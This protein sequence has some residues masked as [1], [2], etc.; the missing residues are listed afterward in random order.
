MSTKPGPLVPPP[1]PGKARHGGWVAAGLAGLVVLA[2][3]ARHLAAANSAAAPGN[4]V[5]SSA[6]APYPSSPVN[7]D[8]V[9]TYNA[10]SSQV[11]QLSGQLGA[12]QGHAQDS[13]IPIGIGT[14]EQL[15]M[16]NP[17][18]LTQTQAAVVH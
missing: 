2:V 14:F 16:Q 6:L 9:Q 13:L 10:L 15:Q 17:R 7:N 12:L 11:S 5:P 1:K 3:Y 18:F 8:A 4:G